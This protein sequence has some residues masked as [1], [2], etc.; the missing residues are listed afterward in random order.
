[1]G[2]EARNLSVAI[3]PE[4]STGVASGERPRTIL[5]ALP[6]AVNVRDIL[7][8]AV[9]R[10]LK[11]AGT[12]LVLLTPAHDDPSFR[13]EFGGEDV[14]IEPLYPNDPGPWEQRFEGLRLTL[15]NDLT[16]TIGFVSTPKSQRGLLKHAALSTARLIGRGL[17]RRTTESLLSRATMTLF[18]DRRYDDVL[19]RYQPD[20]VCLTRVFGWAADCPVLKSAVRLGIPTILL[21]SS[22]D[23][24]TSKGVFPARVDRVVVWNPIMADEAERLHGYAREQIYIAG[25]PQFDVYA[26]DSQLP[27]RSAFF[28]QIGADPDKAL[29]TF[30]M[31][32]VKTCP[33]E[34]DVLEM[35]WSRLREGALGRPAQL[36]ARVH[37]IAS[38]YGEVMPE[39]LR[40][41]PDLLFDLPGRPGRFVD[42]DT[43]R[44]D[45]IHLAATMRHSDVVLNTSS[46]I[47]IDAAA[48]DTPVVC[49]GFD[50][51]RTLPYAQSVRRYHDYTHYSKLLELGGVRV[52]HDLDQL[53]TQV[54]AYLDD[55]DLDHEGRLRII[56]KQCRAIDGKSGE[57]IGQYVLSALD[58]LTRAAA[59]GRPPS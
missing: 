20:L 50:G 30:A 32:N 21:A 17:G 37:P 27:D 34:F 25:A 42:R 9:F 52:A 56:E 6:Y 8:T 53:V 14:H 33:D 4:I 18:P 49:A 5:I 40:N 38:H 36:L 35:F 51:R 24:L 16:K 29:I 26:D 22:W 13:E 3:E 47:A 12:R 43:N 39:R 57:R 19:R 23:N 1:L 58:E 54:K 7:R 44:A 48:V 11:Q 41:L 31:T 46:T 10:T 59:R 55:P 45:M 28:A 2:A 15:F